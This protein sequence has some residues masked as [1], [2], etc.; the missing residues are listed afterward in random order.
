MADNVAN[1]VIRAKDE[2]STVIKKLISGG[3]SALFSPI[4]LATAAFGALAAGVKISADEA[5]EAEKNLT[6]LRSVLASTGGAAGV[7]EEAALALAQSLSETTEFSDDAVLSAENLLLTF[8]KISSD[9]FPQATKITADLAVALKT[10]LNSA[11]MQVGK[12]LNDPIKGVAS[13]GRAGVQF[14]A[15]QKNMIQSL[16]DTGQTAKA[17]QIILKELEMQV[18]GSAASAGNTFAGQWEIAKNQMLNMAESIGTKL[19][20]TFKLLVS[21]L[22]ELIGPIARAF[23][24]KPV[25]VFFKLVQVNLINLI[26]T[27]KT[28]FAIAE[29]VI[30]APFSISVYITALQALGDGIIGAFKAVFDGIKK[31]GRGGLA[32]ME[33][34]FKNYSKNTEN[35]AEKLTSKLTKIETDRK[36]QINAI[37]AKKKTEEAAIHLKTESEKTGT[38]AAH[39][40]ARTKTA[41]D[42]TDAKIKT[43]KDASEFELKTASD[44]FA[45]ISALQADHTGDIIRLNEYQAGTI[46]NTNYSQ[47]ET[48]MKINDAQSENILN[49]T[50]DSLNE[51]L[52]MSQS[53]HKTRIESELAAAASR[54]EVENDVYINNRELID[55]LSA[56]EGDKNAKILDFLKVRIKQEI[57]MQ[58]AAAIVK[59]GIYGLE[60]AIPTF[61][62]SLIAAGA[63]IAAVAAAASTAGSFVDT[64]IDKMKPRENEGDKI[65]RELN[66]ERA[67]QEY[68]DKKDAERE[69]LG[70]T[71]KTTTTTTPK[72]Q[73]T[74]TI[75]QS[76]MKFLDND[77]E[78]AGINRTNTTA[79]AN[80]SANNAGSGGII[81]V[82]VVLD[83]K[84]LGRAIVDLNRKLEAGIL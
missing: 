44:T 25:D 46:I 40:T 81:T 20:P 84:I 30:K 12:A 2:A 55:I 53:F 10:D 42:E 38:S 37:F 61:G 62:G 26:A 36:N 73:M 9:T 6:Q 76:G 35:E 24:S 83:D 71:R 47:A 1:I 19:L 74:Q 60:Y 3:I 72:I 82:N 54:K 63:G 56:A 66:E 75:K 27:L 45:S 13:L 58:A 7:T 43:L 5:I 67:Q 79:Q 59:I 33:E 49:T 52:V 31:I 34:Y 80:K 51:M 65:S 29:S 41:K 70:M 64:E 4:G 18:G 69:R 32:S 22:S 14:S 57:A 16:V 48:L 50:N 77:G 11:A 78:P 68:V 17:Q 39:S 15:D 23:D 21:A 28:T 8:T